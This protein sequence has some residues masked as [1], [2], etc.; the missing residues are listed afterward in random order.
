MGFYSH[1]ERI[2]DAVIPHLL[3]WTV[4]SMIHGNKEIVE[5]FPEIQS[6]LIPALKRAACKPLIVQNKN[7][8]RVLRLRYR[9]SYDKLG[10]TIEKNIKDP[11]KAM[12][13]VLLWAWALDQASVIS[14]AR[15]GYLKEYFILV[16]AVKGTHPDIFDEEQSPFVQSCIK[17]MHKLHEVGQKQH[18]V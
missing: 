14:I 3:Q 13:V 16:K 9:K 18:L 10:R 11:T 1:Q 2:I 8:V 17:Q 4:E 15:C 12:A 5:R 7:A 6:V